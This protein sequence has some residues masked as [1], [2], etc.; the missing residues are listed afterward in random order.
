[1]GLIYDSTFQENTMS[2]TTDESVVARRL[3]AAAT[4]LFGA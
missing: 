2:G 3:D 4:H 1:M